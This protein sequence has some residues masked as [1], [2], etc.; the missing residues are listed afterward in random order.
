M[1]NL[2][3]FPQQVVTVGV[4]HGFKQHRPPVQIVFAMVQVLLVH[5][6]Y[7]GCR[8]GQATKQNL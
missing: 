8:L 4:Q 2:H 6:E 1:K 5:N 3:F 7:A